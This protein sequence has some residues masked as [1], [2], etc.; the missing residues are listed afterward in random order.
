MAGNVLDILKSSLLQAVPAV[1]VAVSGG[2]AREQRIAQCSAALSDV[3]VLPKCEL[4]GKRVQSLVHPS[5]R[6]A[7]EAAVGECAADSSR[8]KRQVWVRLAVRGAVEGRTGGEGERGGAS[9]WRWFEVSASLAARGASAK[10][11]RSSTSRASGTK[12]DRSTST[13]TSTASGAKDAASSVGRAKNAPG[14]SGGDDQR[15]VLCTFLDAT[16]QRLRQVLMLQ[17]LRECAQL[18]TP[19]HAA[20]PQPG[21][22]GGQSAPTHAV[23]PP[24]ASP[25]GASPPGTASERGASASSAAAGAAGDAGAGGGAGAG[26]GGDAAG[27]DAGGRDAGGGDG[28]D[29]GG[30]GD[31]RVCLWR[32]AEWLMERV[33]AALQLGHENAKFRAIFDL[34]IVSQRAIFDLSIVSQRAIFDL[35]IVS[36]RA[37]FDLSIVSQRAIFDLSIVSQRAIFDLSIVSQR[38]IFDLSIV[39]QRVIFDLPIVSQRAIFDLSIVSQRA[40]FD[41]SIVSQRAIFDLS[42]VSQRAIFD[43]SI[44]SQRAIFDLSI[45]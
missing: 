44:V 22:D 1:L 7:F 14:E 12:E 31:E 13:S 43:L 33:K 29:G 36:Q 27:H 38:A 6:A 41:L 9:E 5:D 45:M 24:A 17:Q 39:S 10:D 35:S 3:L 2:N 28:G 19:S 26:A 37:I 23:S 11:G 18:A 42:I 15:M 16:E 32:E 40:I 20:P 30:E 8:R 21:S 34:S 4:S 25:P